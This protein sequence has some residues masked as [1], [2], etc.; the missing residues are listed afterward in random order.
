MICTTKCVRIMIN[1]TIALARLGCLGVPP[2]KNVTTKNIF[3]IRPR[4]ASHTKLIN[5]VRLL[6]TRRLM[7]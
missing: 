5:L 3:L 4:S 1:T 7:L 6:R 2:A